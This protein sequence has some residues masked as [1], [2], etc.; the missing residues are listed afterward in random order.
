MRGV[1]GCVDILPSLATIF[2]PRRT[3]ISTPPRQSPHSKPLEFSDANIN[4]LSSTSST[5]RHHPLFYTPHST[6]RTSLS[7]ITGLSSLSLLSRLSW[8]VW[9]A[10]AIDIYGLTTFPFAHPDPRNLFAKRHKTQQVRTTRM[11]DIPIPFSPF[12]A[13]FGCWFCCFDSPIPCISAHFFH[14][15]YPSLRCALAWLALC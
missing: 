10:R 6:M 9:T 2:I 15:T 8:R 14:N 12:F 11:T 1:V 13:S 3:T 5:M 7:F 4:P